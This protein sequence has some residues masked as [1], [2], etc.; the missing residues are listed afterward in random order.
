MKNLIKLMFSI[1][2]SIAIFFFF[3]LCGEWDF[4]NTLIMSV[5]VSFSVNIAIFPGYSSGDVRFLNAVISLIAIDISLC[6]VPNSMGEMSKTIL[7]GV[8]FY[9][10]MLFA[11]VL[12]I[13]ERPKK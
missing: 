1:L 13:I 11:L 7:Q 3:M 4:V 8:L 6:G 5:L 12:A 10:V 2:I 9:F